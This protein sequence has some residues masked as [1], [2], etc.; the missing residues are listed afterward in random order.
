MIFVKT[1]L[2]I[3]FQQLILIRCRQ[4]LEALLVS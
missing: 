4:Y 2:I 3:N 1:F